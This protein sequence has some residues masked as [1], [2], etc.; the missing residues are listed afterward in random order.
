M[1]RPRLPNLYQE[2]TRYGALVCYVRVGKGPRTLIRGVYG[3][4]EFKAAY[5]AAIAGE[6]GA[7]KPAPN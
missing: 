3:T 6:F 7:P 4:A 1:P 5:L 2:R